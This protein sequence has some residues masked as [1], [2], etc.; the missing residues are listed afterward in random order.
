MGH[1]TWG[2][3]KIKS[4]LLIYAFIKILLVHLTGS[5]KAQSIKNSYGSLYQKEERQKGQDDGELEQA[6]EEDVENNETRL[7]SFTVVK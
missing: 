6:E 2:G 5:G 3:L 4:T 7:L 1:Y